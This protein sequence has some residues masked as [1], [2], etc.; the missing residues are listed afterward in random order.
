M[1]RRPPRS[2]R[3][4]T[5]FP[6]TT[7]FRSAAAWGS[8]AVAG[9]VNI[10]LQKDLEGLPVGAH[11]GISS[12]GDGARYGMDVAFGTAFAGGR[13][14]FLFGAESVEDKGVLARNTRPNLVHAAIVRETASPS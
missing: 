8:G 14:H 12:R 7:L 5:L 6:Y 2:T 1:I 4:D 9:V 10:L 13:G 11:T 3:T